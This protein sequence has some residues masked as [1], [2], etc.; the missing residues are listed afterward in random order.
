MNVQMEL[1]T[2][3][4][5]RKYK[6]GSVSI[7]VDLSPRLGVKCFRSKFVRNVAFRRQ[8]RAFKAGIAPSCRMPF[9]FKQGNVRLY[10]YLT[11]KAQI[12]VD[13]DYTKHADFLKKEL[14]KLNYHVVADDICIWNI[15][16][17]NKRPVC[18]DFTVPYLKDIHS[19]NTNPEMCLQGL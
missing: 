3:L 14:R 1:L 15:G 5:Q 13:G 10:C 7:F 9:L 16:Y 8:T 6:T 11:Q 2:R 18:I 17:I 4:K 12:D 19:G